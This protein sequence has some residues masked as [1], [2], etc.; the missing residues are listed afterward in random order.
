MSHSPDAGIASLTVQGFLESLGAKTPTPGGGA[1]AGLVGSIGAALGRMVV[2]YSA[3]KKSLAA[4]EPLLVESLAAL[5]DAS[6]R[7]LT[8][9]DE[10][11]AAY[12]K[13]NE[14]SR[15]PEADPRRRAEWEAAASKSVEVPLAMMDQCAALLARLERLCGTSN[16][17]LRSDLAIAAIL[18][19][20]GSR[21]AAWNVV[22]NAPNLGVIARD[23]ALADAQ[24]LAEAA[25]AAAAR[26][27]ERCQAGW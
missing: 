7:L 20:A 17:H 5:A 27:E 6:R 3:G 14:L 9:A 18:A 24:R 21:S 2:A 10:D 26:I 8:L 16:T 11:A 4:H 12:A 15:L 1:A 25:R 13:V 19:E 22:V 23:R